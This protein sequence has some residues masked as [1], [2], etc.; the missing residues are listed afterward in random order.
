MIL[1]IGLYYDIPKVIIYRP[2]NKCYRAVISF[3]VPCA[4]LP[5]S[6]LMLI[7]AEGT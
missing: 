7:Y 6:T 5:S 4:H 1:L 2:T 3:V